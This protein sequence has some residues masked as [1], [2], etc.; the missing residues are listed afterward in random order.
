MELPALRITDDLAHRAD[1]YEP[2]PEAEAEQ[3]DTGE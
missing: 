3:Q 1:A 2:K